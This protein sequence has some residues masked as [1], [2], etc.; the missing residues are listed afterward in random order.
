MLDDGG[1]GIRSP[2]EEVTGCGVLEEDR[3][4]KGSS[5]GGRFLDYPYACG[6]DLSG[7]RLGPCRCHVPFCTLERGDC[8][9]VDEG[10]DVENAS[11]GVGVVHF[12]D[13]KRGMLIWGVF[14][15]S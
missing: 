15:R 10:V 14:K 11:Y 1:G 5:C 8:V 6:E 9:D 4:C 3:D 13:S 12:V 2:R 7:R